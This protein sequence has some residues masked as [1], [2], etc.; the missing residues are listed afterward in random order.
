MLW[1]QGVRPRATH[2]F[3]EAV[4]PHDRQGYLRDLRALIAQAAQQLPG[5]AEFI[6]RHCAARRPPRPETRALRGRTTHPSPKQGSMNT[7]VVRAGIVNV[8][9]LFWNF[10]AAHHRILRERL[11]RVQQQRL[12]A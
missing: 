12:P 8:P 4:A 7:A 3:V 2:P 1:G 11:H 5:H 6:A 10:D 9:V